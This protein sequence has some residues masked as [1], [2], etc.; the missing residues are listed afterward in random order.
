LVN[1]FNNC[2]NNWRFEQLAVST[3]GSFD[4]SLTVLETWSK[5]AWKAAENLLETLQE[6]CL[7]TS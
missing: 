2:L 6:N 3:T 1:C 5:T 4:S 7:E